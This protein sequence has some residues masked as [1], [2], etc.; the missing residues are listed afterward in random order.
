MILDTGSVPG[1][2][3]VH[4]HRAGRA[5]GG[6]ELAR[7][8]PLRHRRGRRR[9]SAASAWS[10]GLLAALL[11]GLGWSPAAAR[12]RARGAA[13][14][15][16]R[17]PRRRGRSSGPS[18]PFM[19]GLMCLAAHRLGHGGAARSAVARP[20]RVGVGEQPRLVPARARAAGRR[21]GRD[22]GS[23]ATPRPSSCAACGWAVLGVAARG[24]G[25]PARAASARLPA[26]A[27]RSSR[28]CC[29][30]SSSGGRRPSTASSQRVFIVQ[31][32]GRDRR[33]WP[34][35]PRT[36]RRCWWRCSPPPA[37]LGARNL[38]VASLVLLP[39]MAAGSRRHRVMLASA[40][41]AGGA[42]GGR[43]RRRRR[44]WSLTVARLDAAPTST[45][46]GTRSVALAYLEEH[47]VDTREVRLAAPDIVG[48]LVE[49]RVR[50]R[51]A[52]L[53][54]RSLRHVPGR[55]HRRPTWPSCRPSRPCRTHLDDFD[56]DLVTV[57]R[58]L[59][60][61]PRCSAGSEAWRTLY[62]DDELGA[63]L[64]PGRRARRRHRPLLIDADARNAKRGGPEARPSSSSS[65]SASWRRRWRCRS[66]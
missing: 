30:T 37:L 25:V 9:A 1:R 14:R 38:V 65:S 48:N 35:D 6:A 22:A 31:L 43:G 26:R 20:D 63:A 36:G 49:L 51:A 56:I 58:R 21:R 47:D 17:V 60:D 16:G 29:R 45:S 61:A 10:T 7:V 8:A 41:P 55:R 57:R 12:R 28:T 27:A 39:V 24:G 5:V 46:T 50:A 64:P 52:G 59:A 62:L 40:R 53:L 54:R 33:C 11:A 42:P 13:G 19:V 66:S 15:R 34:G 23:T 18:G 32:A 3:P 4:L 44:S 2:R